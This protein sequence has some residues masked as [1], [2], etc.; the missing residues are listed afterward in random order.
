MPRLS[1]AKA[2]SERNRTSLEELQAA[3]EAAD[4]GLEHVVKWN[5]LL[6]GHPCG[7]A[8]V[9]QRVWGRRPN[10]RLLPPCLSLHAN[11]EFLLEMDAIAVIPQ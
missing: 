8:E 5:I 7:P 1:S 6:Q 10:R 2:I 3:L 11:P 4:A 9:F